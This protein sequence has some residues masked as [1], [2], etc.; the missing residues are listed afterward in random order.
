M[1][2]IIRANVFVNLIFL[3][4]C[5]IDALL[6]S[7]DTQI[8][9]NAIATVTVRTVNLATN[10]QAS[11]IATQHLRA[12]LATNA[13]QL[14]TITPTARNAVAIQLDHWRW[15][16]ILWEAAEL[17]QG[18]NCASARIEWLASTA[19]LASPITGSWKCTIRMDAMI[20]AAT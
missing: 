20:V 3:E 9:K 18:T 17:T 16:D 2:A 12:S 1:I 14:F 15:R 19:I 6:V 4:G 8:A 13:D 10:I 5:A 7:S 11:A